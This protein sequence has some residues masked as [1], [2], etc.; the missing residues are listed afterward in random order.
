MEGEG[1]G[2]GGGG[3]RGE[4]EDMKRRGGG[5]NTNLLEKLQLSSGVRTTAAG[6]ALGSPLFGAIA[7]G[8][9]CRHSR[10]HHCN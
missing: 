6:A 2:G 7:A 8:K 9:G 5:L 4:K 1:D 3:G 10:M